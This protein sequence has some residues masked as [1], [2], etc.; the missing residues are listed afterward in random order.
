MHRPKVNVKFTDYR[1]G[2]S[3]GYHLIPA[4]I[5][6]CLC[7]LA[8]TAGLLALSSCAT[9]PAGVAREQGAV[10]SLSNAVVAL[11]SGAVYLPQPAGGIVEALLAA[12]TAG[13]AAWSAHLHQ[14]VKT[15]KNGSGSNGGTKAASG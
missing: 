6:M 1:K 9:G 5:G 15:L 11:R 7:I 8:V 13:L 14:T 10:D 3:G 12:A 2:S 4:V